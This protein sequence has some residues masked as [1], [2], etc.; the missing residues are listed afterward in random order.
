M[1]FFFVCFRLV[2]WFFLFGWFFTSHGIKSRISTKYHTIFM[3]SLTGSCWDQMCLSEQEEDT[4][5]QWGPTY[6]AEEPVCC[7]AQQSSI[8]IRPTQSQPCSKLA[9]KSETSQQS[10]SL[11]RYWISSASSKLSSNSWNVLPIWSLHVQSTFLFIHLKSPFFPFCWI[12][13]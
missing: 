3:S 5:V 11:D 6:P 9:P 7:I 8:W 12:F 13:P 1:G 2:F 10:S 4:P